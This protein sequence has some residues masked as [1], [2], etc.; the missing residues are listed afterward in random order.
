MRDR[1]LTRFIAGADAFKMAERT[2]AP[3]RPQ[4]D[5]DRELARLLAFEIDA[6]F[7]PAGIQ[8]VSEYRSISDRIRLIFLSLS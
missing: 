2:I 5:A 1:F 8:T 7:S 6:W 3:L 4:I